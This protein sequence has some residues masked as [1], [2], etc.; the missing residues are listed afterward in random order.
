MVSIAAVGAVAPIWVTY[1]RLAMEVCL[2]QLQDHGYF[3]PN[4]S[5][6]SIKQLE[7]GESNTILTTERLCQLNQQNIV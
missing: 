5:Y 6:F 3:V 7:V 4:F 2:L 1:E